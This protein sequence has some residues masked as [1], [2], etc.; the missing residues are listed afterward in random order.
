MGGCILIF[1]VPVIEIFHNPYILY[2]MSLNRQ[3]VCQPSFQVKLADKLLV[4]I[5][6]VELL[7][8]VTG[9]V[10]PHP[11]PFP[12]GEGQNIPPDPAFLLLCRRHVVLIFYSAY[13]S[14]LLIQANRFRF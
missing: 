13:G 14:F 9:L 2:N 10:L 5:V 3:Q 11:N 1:I 12:H 6:V 8:A 4:L 7:R